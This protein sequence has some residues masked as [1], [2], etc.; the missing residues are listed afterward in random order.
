MYVPVVRGVDVCEVRDAR[1]RVV[2]AQ[3]GQRARQEAQRL[4]PDQL[5][6]DRRAAVTSC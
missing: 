2:G 5:A 3:H 4:V 1:E 6:E